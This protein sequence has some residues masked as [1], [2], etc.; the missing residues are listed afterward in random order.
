VDGRNW[1]KADM[2][3]DAPKSAFGVTADIAILATMS[4]N[5]PK[6]TSASRSSEAEFAPL[7]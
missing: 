4:A 6:R 2:V 7:V 3:A 5:D 1:H